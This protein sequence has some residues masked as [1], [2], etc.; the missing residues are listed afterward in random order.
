[1]LLATLIAASLPAQTS[2]FTI[3]DS[4]PAL[5]FGQTAVGVGDVDADGF[6]DFAFGKPYTA[7]GTGEV[8]VHSGRDAH[9]ILRVSGDPNAGALFGWSVAG[10]GD[11]DRD[12]RADLI[13]G[14]IAHAANGL[15]A[16]AVYVVSGRDGKVLHT[17]LGDGPGDLLGS[18]VG[19]VGD[20]DKDGYPELI[21]GAPENG[22]DPVKYYGP[23]Y[24]RVWSGRDGKVMHTFRGVEIASEFGSSVAGAGDIDGDGYLDVLVGS[25]LEWRGVGSVRLYSGRTFATLLEFHG[26]SYADHFGMSVAPAGDVDRDGVGDLLIG[27][28]NAFSFLPGTV[29][30]MS[31]RTGA[32]LH[33][34]RGQPKSGMLGIQV[35]SAGDLDGDGYPDFLASDPMD[36]TRG[37]A[38]GCVRVFSGRTGTELAAVFGEGGGF[39]RWAGTVGDITGDGLP[40]FAVTAPGALAVTVISWRSVV[41]VGTGCGAAVPPQLDATQPVLGRLS[42]LF[43]RHAAPLQQGVVWISGPVTVPLPL[44]SGCAAYLDPWTTS[45]VTGL[46]TDISG[47]WAQS[48]PVPPLPA[49]AGARVALQGG[50]LAAT[51]L[52]AALTNGIAA[53]VQR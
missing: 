24:A 22:G 26:E 44:G 7:N 41:A 42:T 5:N 15:A 18:S 8:V 27:S 40:E 3:R 49:L 10:A 29:W 23:G 9:L 50:V 21:S 19:S 2:L 43:V 30:V 16:G 53:T 28:V 11:L 51:P 32:T 33:K 20:L 34:I 37:T 39:G 36:A 25:L 17:W 52:G 38:T 48:F 14:A 31:G 46:V 6:A 47:R 13:V 12:G 35:A 1:M 45:P 4:N